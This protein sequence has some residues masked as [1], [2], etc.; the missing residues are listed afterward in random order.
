MPERR[1]SASLT[2]LLLYANLFTKANMFSTSNLKLVIY[3]H[4]REWVDSV[5][6]KEGCGSS[7]QHCRVDWIPGSSFP[8]PHWD[9]KTTSREQQPGTEVTKLGK[10]S[11]DC[12]SL[13]REGMLKNISHILQIGTFSWRV[14]FSVVFLIDLS[15]CS[16]K[17]LAEVVCGVGNLSTCGGGGRLTLHLKKF[18]V[19]RILKS[20]VH[21]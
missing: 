1:C 19:L 15:P 3:I 7:D 2:V 5:F 16:D 20:F 11:D 17:R 9:R 18:L 4:I 21:S 10:T 13:G 14:V 12:S 8:H 6:C